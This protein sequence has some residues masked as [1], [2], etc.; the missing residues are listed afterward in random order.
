[1][2]NR[3]IDIV[4]LRAKPSRWDYYAIYSLVGGLL[5]GF[6]GAALLRSTTV[7]AVAN[8]LG[9]MGLVAFKMRTSTYDAR[10][11]WPFVVLPVGLGISLL[12]VPLHSAI[13]SF[14]CFATAFVAGLW[15]FVW[16][17]PPEY[18]AAQKALRAGDVLSA[19]NLATEAVEDY[20]D[21]SEP[22]QLR[23]GLHLMMYQYPEAEQDAR[24]A[25]AADPNQHLCHSALG[26]AL[27]GRQEYAQ[28]REA[29]AKA[30]EL[31]PQFPINHF[32][33]GVTYYLLGEF[34]TAVR[35][36][37][38]S[39]GDFIP[40]DSRFLGYYYLGSSLLKTGDPSAADAAFQKLKKYRASYER[41][42]TRFQEAPDYPSV[43][44]MR[45]ILEDVKRRMD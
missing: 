42:F 29:F 24:E 10:L 16:R 28:A 32:Y 5:V 44:L 7:F 26:Q 13:P 23:S 45:G 17:Y 12:A 1:M 4:P 31:A 14:I 36:F 20:P 6:V 22:Y 39:V 8:L 35:Y 38:D 25:I 15:L 3:N 40:Q 19:L 34:D 41:I 30:L 21:R 18:R 43:Q 9:F 11:V 2:E 33:A 37:K 27:L